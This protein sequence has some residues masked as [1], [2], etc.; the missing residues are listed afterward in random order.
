[1][2][3][4]LF[5]GLPDQCEF[6]IFFFLSVTIFT[7]CFILPLHYLSCM[8]TVHLWYSYTIECKKKRIKRNSAFEV[9]YRWT[10]GRSRWV[11]QR[12]VAP[13]M[14]ITSSF[15]LSTIPSFFFSFFFPSVC[16]FSIILILFILFL[17]SSS[18]HLSLN[19]HLLH[20][21]IF[22]FF[23]FLFKKKKYSAD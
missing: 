23:L 1:M 12:G 7:I 5:C 11:S 20:R 4:F 2:R 22:S 9:R 6:L 21:L 17:S 14:S 15:P 19:P 10:T 16:Y 13:R 18:S 3:I 8:Y